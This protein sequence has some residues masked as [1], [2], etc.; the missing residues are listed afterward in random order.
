M[1]KKLHDETLQINQMLTRAS[2][3]KPATA[4]DKGE[5]G[6]SRYHGFSYGMA[7]RTGGYLAGMDKGNASAV[8]ETRS[9]D[10]LF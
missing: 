10:Q 7:H 3:A 4:E 5:G 1:F 2:T 9:I 6:T 8:G